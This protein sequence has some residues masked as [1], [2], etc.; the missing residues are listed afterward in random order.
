MTLARPHFL[1][2]FKVYDGTAGADGLE[3][4]RT[5]E[6]VAEETGATF[7]VMPQTPDLRLVARETDLPVVAQAVD[8]APE[9]R[10]TGVVLPETVREAGA[11]G[12]MVNHP[13]R[14]QT[15][16][17]VAEIVDRCHSL[18]LDSVVCVA[19]VETG[20]AMA[21]LGPNWL[22]FEKPEDV[23]TER[24][25]TR[26]H[27]ER[28]RSFVAA[29]DDVDPGVKVLVGGGISTAEDVASGFELGV[30]AA[31]AASAALGADD[32]EVWLRSVGEALPSGER[33]R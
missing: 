18:G 26:T 9:G 27:P 31:G 6:R 32:R 14:R 24:A 23:G 19:D 1:I 28:V 22:L 33:S 10:G 3:Y 20:R 8:A 17:E 11:D 21:T 12:V 5:V 15:V 16:P 4:A 30:D 29:I 7:A 25:I 2:N 13:E